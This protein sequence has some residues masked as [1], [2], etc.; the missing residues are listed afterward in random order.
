LLP[1]DTHTHYDTSSALQ[2]GVKGVPTTVILKSGEK[3]E[4]IVGP[5]GKKKLIKTIKS[6]L[7]IQE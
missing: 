7:N 3:I 6:A 1:F 2:Y 4:T 5:V